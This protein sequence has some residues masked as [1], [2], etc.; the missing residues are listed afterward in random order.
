MLKKNEMVLFVVIDGQSLVVN[1]W[2]PIPEFFQEI[3]ITN[4][5]LAACNYLFVG[6]TVLL[7]FV[8]RKPLEKVFG[9]QALIA[10]KNQFENKSIEKNKQA[11]EKKRPLKCFWQPLKVL[12][13]ALR[14]L[15]NPKLYHQTDWPYER[16]VVG[17]ALVFTCSTLVF[18][19][20][21]RSCM[22]ICWLT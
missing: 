1:P 15:E 9:R 14:V 16:L 19:F 2:F 6:R 7:L 17:K 8:S 3:N 22:L 13:K 10:L 11:K 21:V 5:S 18:L 4:K 20:H 12:E